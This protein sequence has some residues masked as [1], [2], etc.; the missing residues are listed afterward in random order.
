MRGKINPFDNAVNTF[1]GF[2][3]LGIISLIPFLF[4]YA[5]CLNLY[6]GNIFLY[7][8][9]GTVT[10]FFLIGSIRGKVVQKPMLRS[11]VNTVMIGGIAAVVSY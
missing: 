8:A 2:N 9:L 3:I 1:V 10:S 11:G 6:T 4:V 7:S 5:L